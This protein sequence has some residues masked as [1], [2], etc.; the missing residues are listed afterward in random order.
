[1]KAFFEK[2]LTV[3][4]AMLI[5]ALLLAGFFTYSAVCDRW[6][7]FQTLEGRWGVGWESSESGGWGITEEVHSLSKNLPLPLRKGLQG[8]CFLTRVGVVPTKSDP[9][10][11]AS[12]G[13][14]EAAGTWMLY[15]NGVAASARCA[16]FT[17]KKRA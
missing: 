9:N 14:D 5:A 13:L 12:V 11:A 4:G 3:P 7:H 6:L 17:P 1:M 16:T 10:A 8:F 15:A 2:L